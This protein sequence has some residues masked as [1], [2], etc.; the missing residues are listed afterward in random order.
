MEETDILIIGAGVVGT[1]IARELSKYKVKVLVLD[2]R[3][4]IGGDAS[5]S[6]SSIMCDGADCPPDTLE[7]RLVQASRR[8]IEQMASDLDFP[9]K[10]IGSIMPAVTE[11]QFALLSK[12][13][14]E[15]FENNI[16]YIERVSPKEILELEPEV[17][18]SVLGGLYNP[19]EA[20]V[21]PFLYV[22]AMAENAAENGVEFMLNTEVTGIIR[23]KEK[24]SAVETNQGTIK[25]K[26][27]INA[28]GLFCDTIAAMIDECDFIVKP[29]KGQF[30]IL[31]KNTPVRINHIIYPI[32]TPSS[33]G[34]LLLPTI[35]GNILAGPTAE[36]LDDK[37]DHSVTAEELQGVA[38]DVRK[39]IPNI[40]I[41]DTITQYAGLRPNRIPQGYNIGFSK[42]TSGYFGITGI[43]S[44][45][46]SGS[47]GIAK[48]TVKSL[49]D[50]GM[51][52]QKKANFIR[53]RRSIASFASASMEEQDTLIA[54]DDAWANIIC[55]C[56]TISEAEIVEAIQRPLGARTMDA[57][58]RR[59]RSGMGRCQGGF[60]GP[61][62]IEILSRE[63]KISKTEICKNLPGSYMLNQGTINY[64]D[65]K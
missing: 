37:E 48:Y 7:S 35:H 49:I 13:H 40:R 4:D 12:I 28:A 20:I 15:A 47:Q 27:I 61:Q 57:I 30:F 65:G 41:Q 29:R 45:G 51:D 44:T 22:V 1:A 33:R 5:K 32:P 39:L 38:D 26:C 8:M 16:F 24:V 53:K 25:T 3:D 34:K 19:N 56:E 42:K 31:D 6:N 14:N 63:L 55:R 46:V 60:C 21:D 62:I 58:K 50:S 17:N 43:R 36:D 64:G 59:V 9:L 18:P 10:V 52:L 11:E 54:K 2:K 23:D